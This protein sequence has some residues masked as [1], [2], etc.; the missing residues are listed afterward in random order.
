M[1]NFN[2][3]LAISC[4]SILS[5]AQEQGIKYIYR[6]R[7]REKEKQVTYLV[8]V[9]NQQNVRKSLYSDLIRITLIAI[10]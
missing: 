6:E 4:V 5:V 9:N 10:Q 3:V 7:E 1:M 2:Q 8:S